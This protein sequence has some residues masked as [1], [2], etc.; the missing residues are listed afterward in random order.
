MPFAKFIV[1]PIFV[2]FQAFTMMLIAPYIP[3]NS[4]ALAGG[5]MSW[6]A[7]QAWAMYFMAGCTPKMAGK[8]FLGYVGGIVASIAIFRLAGAL[9][10]LNGDKNLWGLYLAVFVVVVFVISAERVPGFDFV[11]SYF[12]GAGVFFGLMTHGSD[13]RPEGISDYAWYLQVAAPIL[14]ACVVGLS[15]GWVTVTFRGWYEARVSPKAEEDALAA[16]AE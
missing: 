13:S 14:V 10:G 11:P 4:P 2:A 3:G 12:I 9:Q 15:Y 6:V 7:F 8:T 1:I 5:L 16:A